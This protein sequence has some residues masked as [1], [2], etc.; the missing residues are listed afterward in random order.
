M[1][2]LNNEFGLR[3]SKNGAAW[4][5]NIITSSKQK[6]TL[7]EKLMELQRTVWR[8]SEAIWELPYL[9]HE[10]ITKS[11]DELETKV[12][13]WYLDR[14]CPDERVRAIVLN[15]GYSEN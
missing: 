3:N 14:R 10:Q 8:M 13:E 7:E 2:W 1:L 5:Q 4:E 12:H 9:E 6:S 15:R 11:T